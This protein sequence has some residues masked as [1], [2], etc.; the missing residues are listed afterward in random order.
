[1]LHLGCDISHKINTEKHRERKKK[2]A[3]HALHSTTPIWAVQQSISQSCRFV[4]L[5][6]DFPAAPN[7]FNRRDTPVNYLAKMQL[8]K[9]KKTPN[10]ITQVPESWDYNINQ[11]GF[12]PSSWWIHLQRQDLAFWQLIIL[13]NIFPQ[14]FSVDLSMV[15]IPL[16]FT[17]FSLQVPGVRDVVRMY[18]LFWLDLT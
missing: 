15:W 5:G 4:P 16:M 3:S 8:K 2:K 13:F 6:P 10:H 1:M 7:S 14:L 12:K 17:L 18:W 9:K 11:G